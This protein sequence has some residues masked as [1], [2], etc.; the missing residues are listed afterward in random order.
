MTFSK[1]LGHWFMIAAVAVVAFLAGTWAV[2]GA[3]QE[4]QQETPTSDEVVEDPL[5]FEEFASDAGMPFGDP[6]EGFFA[7]RGARFEGMR[8]KDWGGGQ[9][10]GPRDG[11]R[12][13]M[14][15][16][17]RATAEATSLDAREVVQQL[18]DGSSLTA[19][20]EANGSSEQAVIEAALAQLDERL[21][22]AVENG[23]STEAEKAT[24]LEQARTA[25][26]ALMQRA[27][28]PLQEHG[29]KA[30]I[31]M[32]IDATAEVTGLSGVQVRA[33]L[34]AGQSLAQIAEANG[35]TAA[36]ILAELR[37]R[38]EEKLEQLLE[39][40]EEHINSV[41]DR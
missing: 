16:L 15:A 33:E 11:E 24:A 27:G 2:A 34:E 18:R 8:G 23:R 41:P 26:P 35:K 17:V 30:G 10:G 6:T 25:A 39:R 36:D 14:G 21:T 28:L 12:I 38:G 9:H 19:I 32:L 31:R 7:E 1:T 13:L 37:T 5:L 20:V 3:A 4:A 40:A 22:R 29:R